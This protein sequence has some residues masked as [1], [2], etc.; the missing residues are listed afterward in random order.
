MHRLLSEPAARH[1]P[2]PWQKH[3]H[4]SVSSMSQTKQRWLRSL[5][6][7]I[8]LSSE[9]SIVAQKQLT[10]TRR[11]YSLSTGFPDCSRLSTIKVKGDTFSRCDNSFEI[12][13]KLCVRRCCNVVGV[14][15][16]SFYDFGWLLR[17]NFC[18]QA[19]EILLYGFLIAKG[20]VIRESKT[21][22]FS[23]V[24]EQMFSL[25]R[26]ILIAFRVVRMTLRTDSVANRY[27]CIKNA[28]TPLILQ[29][30]ESTRSV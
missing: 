7:A 20:L 22:L 11:I 8:N 4:P 6:P 29:G 1:F 14:M 21:R 24:D 30:H 12:N 23:T 2:K 28:Q 17:D 19:D 15:L 9:S 3:Q 18:I 5:L 27:S 10:V 25:E 13:N 26:S 16:K